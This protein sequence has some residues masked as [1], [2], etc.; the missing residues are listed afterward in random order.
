MSW[1]TT[2]FRIRSVIAC[3]F[4]SATD[5]DPRTF[6][7]KAHKVHKIHILLPFM[8]NCAIQ[9]VLKAGTWSSQTVFSIFFNVRI[10][11]S[12]MDTSFIDPVVA[13]QDIM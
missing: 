12:F 10:H 3:T 5:E 8:E 1:H 4:K 13:A 7:V 6:K 9:Q 2:S 11:H